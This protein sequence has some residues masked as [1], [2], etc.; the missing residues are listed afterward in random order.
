M[1]SQLELVIKQSVDAHY[2]NWVYEAL[3]ELPCNFTLTDPC[4][5]GNPIVFASWG[6]LEM[7]GYSRDEVIGR[8]GRMFQGKGTN[9]GTVMEIREAIR[10]ERAI[11]VSLLNYHKNG[12]PFWILF[13]MS[14][15]FSGEDGRVIHFVAVQ[16]PISRKSLRS[17]SGH[18]RSD[19][20]LCED[21]VKSREFL[22]G[23]CR[24]EVCS[25]SVSEL[26]HSATFDSFFDLD[27]GIEVEEFCEA[28]ELDKQKATTS[29]SNILSVLTQYSA[30]R[31]KS[32]SEKSCSVEGKNIL[33][34]ALLTSLGCDRREVLGRKHRFLSGSDTD[35]STLLQVFPHRTRYM[36]AFKMASHAQP[37]S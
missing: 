29:I 31:G 9:R 23:S 18:G 12:T 5:S 25:D 10:E 13:C 6:F 21:G 16:V 14:P 7:F 8:N 24:R 15:V 36:S 30:L 35:P 28:S 20:C 1:E 17:G 37:E 33:N 19:F 2:S 22:L 26:S 4:I 32:I 34:S 27:V 3:D 11:Q